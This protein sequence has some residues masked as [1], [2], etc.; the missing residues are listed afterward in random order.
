M[1]HRELHG[2]IHLRKENFSK[3]KRN[4]NDWKVSFKNC[5]LEAWLRSMHQ[6]GV[7]GETVYKRTGDENEGPCLC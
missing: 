2:V 7:E 3:Q 5:H 4:L 1:G 6:K